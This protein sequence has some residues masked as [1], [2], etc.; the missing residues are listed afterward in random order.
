MQ[1]GRDINR[2]LC[3][4]ILY[5]EWT[6]EENSIYGIYDDLH[7]REI[8]TRIH[9]HTPIVVPTAS[10]INKRKGNK[11]PSIRTWIGKSLKL[12]LIPIIARSTA[13][14]AG[15]V[16]LQ[17]CRGSKRNCSGSKRIKS[18]YGASGCSWWRTEPSVWAKRDDDWF[19]P[20]AGAQRERES[21]SVGGV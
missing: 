6:W 15:F 8:G 5:T 14:V 20:F 17:I 12:C 11:S 21:G 19:K 10:K 13:R 18:V 7:R 1:D 2:Y 3:V 4:L 16:S 9:T